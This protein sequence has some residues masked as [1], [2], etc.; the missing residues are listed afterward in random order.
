MSTLLD[1]CDDRERWALGPSD[2]RWKLHAGADGVAHTCSLERLQAPNRR[3]VIERVPPI[4]PAGHHDACLILYDG[5]DDLGVAG[6]FRERDHLQPDIEDATF[7]RR[8]RD[9]DLQLRVGPSGGIDHRIPQRGPAAPDHL[10]ASVEY[11]LGRVT[12]AAEQSIRTLAR[13]RVLARERIKPSELV[14]VVDVMC[15]HDDPGAGDWLGRGELA[16]DVVRR[17]AARATLRGE[18]LEQHRCVAFACWRRHHGCGGRGGLGLIRAENEAHE[19]KDGDD[20]CSRCAGGEKQASAQHPEDVRASR[21]TVSW[22][23]T[24]SA[25]Q[26]HISGHSMAYPRATLDHALEALD[27]GDFARAQILATDA[28]KIAETSPRKK[29]GE[30]V[31]RATDSARAAARRVLA[32]AML[33]DDKTDEAERLA[34]E[35]IR[36]ARAAGSRRET[37]LAELALAEIGRARGDYVGGLRH[38]AR[39]RHLAERANDP[40]T[41]ATVLSDYAL[42]LSRVGDDERARETFD[43]L[44]SSSQPGVPAPVESLPRPRA[45]RV[46]YNAAMAH[47][48]AGRFDAALQLL[49]RAARLPAFPPAPSAEWSLMSARLLTLIDL[50]AYED[51]RVLL[52]RVD[53]TELKASWQRAQL[54]ALRAGVALGTGARFEVVESFVEEGLALE[55]L[56]LPLVHALQRV[57][58][59]SLLS[60]GRLNEAERIAIGMLASSR[61]RANAA[62]ALAIAAR[63]GAPDAWLLRWL[64]AATA[65]MSGGSARVEHEAFSGLVT[66]PEPIGQL[67]RNT[68]AV[69]RAKLLERTPS[70]YRKTL[71]RALRQVEQRTAALRSNKRTEVELDVGDE[72]L[73]VKDE[74]GIAG[75]SP[76]LMRALATV[77]R[78]ARSNA[79]LVVTGE[80]GAGKELFA[81]FAHRLSPRARAPFVAVNCAAIPHPLLEAELFGHE[82]G[83]F[84]GAERSRQGLF[85][86]SEGGT[87]FLDEVGEMS[88]AMQTKLL[89]VLEDGEV[90]AVGGTRSRKVDVRVIAATH[91]D[92]AEMVGAGTFR[93]DLFYR[94]AAITVRIPALRDRPEDLP[95]IARILLARDTATKDHRLDIPGLAML[96]E[97]PWPGNVRELANVLRVAAT[98]VEGSVIGREE[99]VAAIDSSRLARTAGR[100]QTEQDPALRETTLAELRTRHKA[101]LRALVGRAIAS[102]DGNKKRAARSLGVSR[103]GLYRVLETDEVG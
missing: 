15:K 95:A 18:E 30:G 26:C 40:R 8:C 38:A 42:L 64:G 79:S 89:R 71:G 28:L 55:G 9:A 50:G 24:E 11:G 13:S 45:L 84:T 99:L 25:A 86:E 103:Q 19:E 57:R 92:L 39:A 41:Q 17:R 74:I 90:R 48:A 4:L 97:H 87:L 34:N 53:D 29:S 46:F 101:E 73:R 77:A 91:R 31:E 16:R 88:P 35:A 100:R 6:V 75:T 72:V 63:A 68:L 66:E 47:R 76:G 93:E 43:R 37:A 102:A 3:H 51:A 7:R 23:L 49:D 36:I 32:L 70:A 52:E 67:A 21:R 44:V 22:W 60:R 1:E 65:S 78:A 2:R 33:Y 61:T 10:G 85:L 80:T 69:L 81:R 56:G 27:A 14:P 59:L 5:R 20:A 12:T 94:L 62:Q 54:L 83:A 82:R 58:A 98:M 96:T